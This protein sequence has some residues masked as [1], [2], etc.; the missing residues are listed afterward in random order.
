MKT[1]ILGAGSL[2]C[3]YGGFLARAGNDV[4]LIGR[5]KSQ[6]D[7][8]NNGLIITGVK[9]TQVVKVK[10]TDNPREVDS[11][12]LL[13]LLTKTMDSDAALD[14]VSHLYKGL[15]CAVSLQNGMTKDD[16]LKEKLGAEKVIGGTAMVGA[17]LL[18]DGKVEYTSDGVTTLG[19]LDGR[20]SDRVKE[21]VRMLNSAGLKAEAVDDIRSAEWT[22]LMFSTPGHALC[23]IT[24]LE[25]HKIRQ[26]K[27]LAGLYVR[28]I[29]ETAE[30][31]KKDG[32]KL[33]PFVGM[34][35]VA[36]V[37][38]TPFDQAVALV[39][40][41]GRKMEKAGMIHLLPSMAQSLIAGRKTEVDAT[42]GYVAKRAKELGVNAPT[43]EFCAA[44]IKGIDEYMK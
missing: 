7:A 8:V 1:I 37:V 17:V 32:A 42:I 43:A 11:A 31:A 36:D 15:K 24:R 38:N 23:G 2:G 44:I 13:I 28:L 29:K 41:N 34:E 35:M 25:M 12:D 10:A 40:E 5:R 4:T 39:N 16:K 6:V 30:V 21:V 3:V 20:L 18:G 27:L 33:R 9:G 19:E 26:S 22:K 14:S